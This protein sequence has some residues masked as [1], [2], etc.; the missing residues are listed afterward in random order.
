M[1]RRNL[2]RSKSLMAARKKVK[3]ASFSMRRNL[4]T[5]RRMI[6]GCVEVDEET[7]FQKSVE[8]IVMLKMQLGILKS[9]LKI[10][11]S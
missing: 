9:L 2:R 10:Y 4:Y 8:H 11:E 1:N 5:L 6:P 7:L 3:L